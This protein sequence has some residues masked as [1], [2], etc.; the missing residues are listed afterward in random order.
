MAM[1]TVVRWEPFRE[2][3]SVQNELSRFMNGLFEGNGRTA[4]DWVP[5]LDVWET[6]GE[7]VY[8]LDLPGVPEDKIS[9]ELNEGALSITAERERSETVAEGRFYRYERRFGT[10]S[11]TVGVPEGVTDEDVTATH[12]DGVLEIHVRKPEAP[13]PRRITIGAKP[14]ATIEGTAT[15]TS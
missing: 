6:D 9:I 13:K 2:I 12:D 10:F 5:T 1:A 7:L 3:A 4:Q 8:A 15:T 11:R 14:D